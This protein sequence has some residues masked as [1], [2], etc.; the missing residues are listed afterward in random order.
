MSAPLPSWVQGQGDPAIVQGPG[1]GPASDY[2]RRT[3]VPLLDGLRVLTYDVRNTGRAAR[4]PEPNSQSTER[5]V[6]DLEA[7]REAHGMTDFVLFGHS[8]GA[9]VAMGYAIRHPGRARALVLIAPS[10]REPDGGPP[11]GVDAATEGDPQRA[12]ALRW[13]ARAPRDPRRLRDDRELARWLRRRLVVDF[14]DGE[15]RERFERQLVGAPAPSI[16]ALRGMPARREEWVRQGLRRLDLPVLVVAGGA[17]RT[18]PVADAREVQR[19]IPGAR[20]A[21]LQRAGH[22]PWVERPE[23]FRARLREFFAS[24]ERRRA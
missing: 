12:E 15:A 24:V 8:H 23:E 19:S 9:F 5:L 22:N 10:L 18:T 3:L 6:A 11:S 17:D 7:V 13:L 2:L 1:W 20:F 4:V 14:V 21:L 16:V